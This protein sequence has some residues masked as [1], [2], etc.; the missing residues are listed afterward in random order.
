[1]LKKAKLCRS[2]SGSLSLILGGA[3]LKSSPD[4]TRNLSSAES[5]VVSSDLLAVCIAAIFSRAESIVPWKL[6]ATV[7]TALTISCPNEAPPDLSGD[8]LT[9]GGE[10]AR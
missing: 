8:D 6:F 4:I 3:T 9:C 1:M 2:R 10:S 5:P 7:S